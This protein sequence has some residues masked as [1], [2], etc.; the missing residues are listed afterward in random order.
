MK[1]NAAVGMLLCGAT[2]ALLSRENV[3]QPARIGATFAALAQL[4]PK[5]DVERLRGVTL[6]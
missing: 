1:A 6:S 5:Q 2:L 3:A 4:R